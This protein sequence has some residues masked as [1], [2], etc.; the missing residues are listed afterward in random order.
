MVLFRWLAPV[1]HLLSI[2]VLEMDIDLFVF[3]VLQDN[4]PEPQSYLSG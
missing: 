3:G 4:R 2:E 1:N